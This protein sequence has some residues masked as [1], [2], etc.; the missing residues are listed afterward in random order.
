MTIICPTILASDTASYGKQ[1]ENVISFSRRI[2][3]DL[4]DGEFSTEKN[5]NLEDVWLPKGVESDI[6]LMYKN[7]QD[8]IGQLIKLNPS[9][10]IVHAESNCDIPLFA[11]RLR[12]ANIKT[13]LAI[14]QNTE[15]DSI[16][17]ILPH[18]Q[19]LLIF[20]GELGHFGGHADL[21][22]ISKIAEAKKISKHIEIGWDGG[23]N[24]NN[25]EELANAGVN[26]INV[27]SA[28]QN[29]SDPS[30]AYAKM[31]EKLN[32]YQK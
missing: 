26:V 20:S 23:A 4:M 10:V 3:I 29:A 6:H 11:A 5:L 8:Y 16:K 7:P 15:V 30:Y 32:K 22:L 17:Y 27:G 24:L 13:G 14:L 1:V 12:E 19:H 31:E 25:I 2:Q 28:L 18:V 9:M 21:S